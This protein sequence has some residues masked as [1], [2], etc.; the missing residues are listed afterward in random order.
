[1]HFH[2]DTL[3][4]LGGKGELT[5][6]KALLQLSSQDFMAKADAHYAEA[7]AFVRSCPNLVFQILTKRPRSASR[8]TSRRLWQELPELPSPSLPLFA[9]E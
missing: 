4:E 7:W 2:L 6:I 1:M 8:R 5:S 3:K 9:G